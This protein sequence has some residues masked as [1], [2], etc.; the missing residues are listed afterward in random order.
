MGSA[1]RQALAAAVDKLIA[2]KDVTIAVG[3]QLLT[4]SR[5]V[6]ESAQLR[7]ILADP[8]VVPAEKSRLLGQIF[9]GLSGTAA[10]I[11]GTIVAGRWSDGE[12]LVDGLEQIGIHAIAQGD[13][14]SGV[15]ESELF[16]FGGVVS[17]EASLELALGNKLADPAGK[18]AIVQQLIG[19]KA[20]AGT[21]AIVEH[22]VR[23]PRGRRIG[24]MLATAAD[25][26]ASAGARRIATVTSAAP[27]SAAQQ[28]RLAAALTKQYGSDIQLH[29]VTDP[30]VVGGARVQVG[31][32]VIDGTIAS[33][34]ADLKLQ[35]AG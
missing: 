15:I 29:L 24:E 13:G 21:V 2:T 23:S 32:D 16:E 33:R 35:L 18:A 5:A 14:H 34:L 8:S 30:A 12:E 28:K 3:E 17:R 1:S 7:G 20:H 4:V 22:L 25:I 10:G 6:D 27:L 31:D 19:R 26:V 9:P 11:A